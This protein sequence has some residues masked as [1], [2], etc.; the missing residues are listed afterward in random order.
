VKA[1]SEFE[2]FTRISMSV[3]ML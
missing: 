3:I 2:V 1:W